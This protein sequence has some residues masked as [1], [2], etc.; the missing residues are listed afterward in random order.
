MAQTNLDLLERGNWDIRTFSLRSAVA[1]SPPAYATPVNAD[2]REER[3]GGLSS[4]ERERDNP[5]AQHASRTW[6]SPSGAIHKPLTRRGASASLRPSPCQ[7]R[8]RFVDAVGDRGAVGADRHG[9]AALVVGASSVVA[10]PRSPLLRSAVALAPE[11]GAAANAD[12]DRVAG[13]RGAK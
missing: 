5:P 7:Q 10:V 4:A 8:S 2:V 9:D 11:H 6:P 12:D 3:R 13:V 1:T